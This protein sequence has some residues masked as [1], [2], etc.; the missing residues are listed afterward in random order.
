MEIIQLVGYS[1]REKLN[2][3]KQYLIPRQ[4]KENGLKP[5]QLE[6]DTRVVTKSN[7]I[8]CPVVFLLFVPVPP[9]LW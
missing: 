6:M 7:R 3:A 8:N 2:I 1:D 9:V 5:E 4:I